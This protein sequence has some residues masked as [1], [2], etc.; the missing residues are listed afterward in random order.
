M[1]AVINFDAPARG[2]LDELVADG[3]LPVLADLRR[4]GSEVALETPS[5]L[6]TAASYPS[7]WTGATAAE[8]GIYYP[9]QWVAEEMRVHRADELG[10]P[11]AFWERASQAGA[12]CIVVDAYEAR[13]PG[14]VRGAFVAGCQF[15]NR[16]VLPRAVVPADAA[17]RRGA[18]GPAVDEVFGAPTGRGLTGI[19]RGLR[20]GAAR[21]AALASRLVRAHGP[22]LVVLGLPVVHLAG[23]QLLDPDAVL[24]GGATDEL[25]RGLREIVTEADAALAVLLECLPAG[26]DLVVVTPHGMG[27]N[28]SR[29][30]LT[31]P[32]LE[33][34]LGGGRPREER[35]DRLRSLVPVS[36]R[37]RIARA[38][39]ATTAL[40]LAARIATPQ[41]DWARTRA[42]SVPSDTHGL[43]RLNLAGRERD[44][45][46][47][48]EERDGLIEEIVEG[49]STFELPDGSPLVTAVTRV[50][51]AFGPGPRIHRLP[52]LAVEWSRVRPLD[53]EVVSSPRFGAFRGHG[54]ASGR[55]GNHTSEAWALLVPGRSTVRP[56]AR[57]P[58]V[59]DV[60]AT[61]AAALGHETAGEALLAPA[62]RE[63]AR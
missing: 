16:V 33:A 3:S 12:T 58:R 23:H 59:E 11:P 63:A 17:G 9:F 7:L 40:R 46:V 51:D 37:A 4:R 1:L 20:G 22:D 24:R 30:D 26:A 47:R 35:V 55:S 36:L 29:V 56:T 10:Q 2:L 41:H 31:T 5:G 48:E 54:L 19:L 6:L 39:P 27:P 45:I 53:G 34:V 60:A 18:R 15:S 21:A 42:F 28:T 8:H 52:D 62:V 38:L 43:V 44:G 57:P 50:H 32:I 13:V 49:L 25:R 14:D 61:V